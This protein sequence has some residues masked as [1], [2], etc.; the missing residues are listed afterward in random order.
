MLLYTDRVT[1]CA[2]GVLY[3][4]AETSV[5]RYSIQILTMHCV[6][7]N[8]SVVGSFDDYR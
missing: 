5:N 3:C 1:H 6:F 8:H 7:Q 2:T 4:I